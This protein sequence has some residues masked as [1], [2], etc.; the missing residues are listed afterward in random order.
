MMFWFE[1]IIE[2]VSAPLR[3]WDK[4]RLRYKIILFLLVIISMAGI[5][6]LLNQ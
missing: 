2:I 3:N 5:I 1:S 6:I 4:L